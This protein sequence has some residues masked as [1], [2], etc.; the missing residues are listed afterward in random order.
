[1][2]LF[3][4]MLNLHISNDLLSAALSCCAEISGMPLYILSSIGLLLY[5]VFPIGR[6][7]SYLTINVFSE[8]PEN[9]CIYCCLPVAVSGS[10]LLPS[11]PVLTRYAESMNPFAKRKLIEPMV[12]EEKVVMKLNNLTVPK[13]CVKLN[14]LQVSFQL[15]TYSL[16]IFT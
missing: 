14:T 16:F 6:P 5:I 1:M 4:Q 9:N 11:A 15:T 3:L 2:V 7:C 8:E 12:P 10:T 13:L